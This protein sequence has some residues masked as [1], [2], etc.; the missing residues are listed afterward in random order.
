[1]IPTYYVLPPEGPA[2]PV[3]CAVPGPMHDWVDGTRPERMKPFCYLPSYPTLDGVR[4]P[5][6]S[7]DAL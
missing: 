2:L 4:F 1:V 6:Y 3:P 7:M 5:G